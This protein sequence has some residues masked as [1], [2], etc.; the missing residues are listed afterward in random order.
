MIKIEKVETINFDNEAERK[1][2]LNAFDPSPLQDKLL[3]IITHFEKQELTEALTIAKTLK[4]QDWEYLHWHL[5]D[6]LANHHS[7]MEGKALHVS[8]RYP[9]EQS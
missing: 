8:Y 3:G 9:K 1:R 2:I 5:V 7:R 4:A 6:I